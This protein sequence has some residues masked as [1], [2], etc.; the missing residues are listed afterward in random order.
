MLN[1]ELAGLPAYYEKW[2]DKGSLQLKP[3]CIVYKVVVN[4]ILNM[5]E[6]NQSRSCRDHS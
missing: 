6:N 2:V 1:D 5:S 4:A 3:V